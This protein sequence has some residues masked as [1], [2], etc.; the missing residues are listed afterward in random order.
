MFFNSLDFAIFLPIVFILYW[1][2]VN[3]NKMIGKT[4]KK[5][6]DSCQNWQ[7]H[8]LHTKSA[9]RILK[10]IESAKGKTDRKLIKLSNE[11][12]LNKL[13]WKG[14]APWLYVY[15]TMNQTFKSDWIPDNYYGKIVVP[16]IKEN[17][18]KISDYNSLNKRLFKSALFL[19]LLYFTNGLWFFPEYHLFKTYQN[20]AI[21][22]NIVHFAVR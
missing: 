3:K 11:Y 2:V 10:S 16:K 14:F 8:F 4:A 13:G 18:G 7:Y 12:A 9:N 17:Y 6:K 21:T 5:L 19:D 1:F 20:H 22:K 15:G